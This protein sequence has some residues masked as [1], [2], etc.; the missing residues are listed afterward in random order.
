LTIT[1]M[2][3]SSYIEEICDRFKGP[4]RL[5]QFPVGAWAPSRLIK[6]E[7]VPK[8]GSFEVRF[9]D[10]TPSQYFYWDD[11][12]GRRLRP[13]QVDSAEASEERAEELEHL[14]REIEIDDNAASEEG[15]P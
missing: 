7:V 12:A 11:V 2:I 5:G 1:T 4:A 6:R 3:S 10:G 9:S 13:A 8:C 15:Q 14:R